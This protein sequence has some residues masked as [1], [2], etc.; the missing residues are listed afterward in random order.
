MLNK[1]EGNEMLDIKSTELHSIYSSINDIRYTIVKNAQ[2]NLSDYTED[3]LLSHN[4]ADKISV[5]MLNG[6]FHIDTSETRKNKACIV[7]LTNPKLKMSDD[8]KELHNKSLNFIKSYFSQFSDMKIIFFAIKFSNF[9]NKK[10]LDKWIIINYLQFDQKD[11]FC[12]FITKYLT[13]HHLIE[14][15]IYWS[16]HFA[17]LIKLIQGNLKNLDSILK[18]MTNTYLNDKKTPLIIATFID[19]IVKLIF[20]KYPDYY[21]ENLTKAIYL[22]F[23]NIKYKQLNL[24]YKYLKGFL[25]IE[26]DS[27]IYSNKSTIINLPV[28]FVI[29]TIND[30]NT[31]INE[32]I[33]CIEYT[34]TM[35]H[36]KALIASGATLDIG[37]YQADIKSIISSFESIYQRTHNSSIKEM[38]KMLKLLSATN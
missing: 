12:D 9:L 13:E 30:L 6:Q 31:L 17:K 4:K 29:L 37:H 33:D 24:P 21:S 32:G 15:T 16:D 8:D 36:L 11:Q 19:R 3:C 18:P 5:C 1:K 23:A 38:I 10:E 14:Y 25:D 22:Q 2:E 20:T 26:L 7:K 35:D 27:S 34:F 28:N